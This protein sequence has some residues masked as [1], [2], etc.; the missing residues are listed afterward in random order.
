MY[1]FWS[2]IAAAVPAAG[3]DIMEDMVPILAVILGLSLA[4]A[5]VSLAM[6]VGR[7]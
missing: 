6:R 4:A 3:A 5:V 7:G 1:A 2:S